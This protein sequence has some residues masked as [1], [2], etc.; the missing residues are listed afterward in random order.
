VGGP[1][2]NWTDPVSLKK[3]GKENSFSLVGDGEILIFIGYLI[4]MLL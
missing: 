3:K 2:K 4:L 1:G